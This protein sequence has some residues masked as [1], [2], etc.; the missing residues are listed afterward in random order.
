MKKIIFVASVLLILT[1][2]FASCYEEGEQQTMVDDGTGV[3]MTAIVK[4]I[5]DKIEV[6]VI[7]GEYGVSGIFWVN[8]SDETVFADANN[9]VISLSDLD[10][11]DVVE[12][13][14]GGQVA[15]SYPPQI[16]AKIIQIK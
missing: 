3:K 1:L 6:E 15:M 11:G 10:I 9:T 16:S 8:Y 14:Y 2:L 5:G 4:N 7:E 13:T 12:I